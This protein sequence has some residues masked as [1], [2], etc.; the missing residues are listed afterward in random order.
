MITFLITYWIATTI[1]GVYWLIKNPSS[2]HG[3]DP[4]YFT[5]LELLGKVFPA[6]L[7]GWVA[8]P[9]FLLHQI[10]FRRRPSAFE[11]TEEMLQRHLFITIIVI[12]FLLSAVLTFLIMRLK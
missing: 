1:Y 5:L 11:T 6:M 10:K 3:D 8:V 2:R 7:I 12:A 4:E 9:L